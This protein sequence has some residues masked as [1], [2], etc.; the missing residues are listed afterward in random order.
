M[1]KIDA[2]ISD[3]SCTI[4]NDGEGIPIEKN[5]I[6]GVYN[7]TLIFGHLLSGSNYD[8]KQKRFTSGRNGLGAKL[9]N[10]FAKKFTVTGVDETKR[11]Q[12]TQ[13]W[14]NNMRIVSEPKITKSAKKSFTSVSFDIDG[15]L[16]GIETIPSDT[17]SLFARFTLDAAM[18][19][20]LKV[21]LNGVRLPNKLSL[22]L[23]LIDDSP[24][25]CVKF[26]NC[27]SRVW[28]SA[29]QNEKATFEAISFVN[30]SCT[31]NGGRHV[32]AVVEAVCRPIIAKLKGLATLRE[33]KAQLRFL[34]VTRV[35][36]PEYD[37][38]EKNTLESP[39]VKVDPI[40]VAMVNKILKFPTRDGQTIESALKRLRESKEKREISKITS[41]K[42]APPIE[43]YDR[44]NFA[45][46]A[47][48][49]ECVLS[50]CEGLSAKTFAVAGIETGFGGKRGRNYFGIYP[51]KGK[52]LNTR[53]VSTAILSKNVVVM[54]LIKI[55]G[56]DYSNPSNFKNL[57]YGR[58]CTLTDADVDGIHIEC[59]ILNFLHST[60][61]KLLE[62][63]FA[64]GMKTPILKTI[65]A[66]KTRLYFDERSFGKR[67]GC[68]T[69]TS[70]KYFKGLGTTKPE[71]VKHIFGLKI[72][73]FF[74]DDKT[75]KTFEVAFNK[76]DAESR[77]TLLAKYM[78]DLEKDCATLDD[79]TE[80]F[81]PYSISKHLNEQL[82]KF[83]YDDCA[84]TLPSIYDGLKES[85]RKAVYAAKQ[86]NL[87]VDLKV[88]QFGA[89]VA[90]CTNYHHGEVNLFNTIIKMA[91]SFTGS[92][93]VPLFAEEGMFGTRLC[94][95]ED[96]ASPRYIYTKMTKAMI[97]LF[98]DDDIYTS[99]V[100]DGEP[101]EPSYYVPV[102][103]MLL[104][105]GCTGIAS[106]WMCSCPSFSP[107]DVLD[108]ARAAINDRELQPIKPW[109]RGFTGQTIQ[110]ADGKFSTVGTFVR[111][112]SKV[113]VTE[114]P[115]GLWND[116]FKLAC[117]QDE[118]IV[119]V[120]DLSTAKTPSFSLTVAPEFDEV[121]FTKRMTT[122][123]NTNNIVAF[124]DR[125]QI[126]RVSVD[127][128]FK[129]WAKERLRLN[130]IRK[131]S[132]ISKLI[133]K[134][135]RLR[136]KIKFIKLVK[137]RKILLTEKEA[138][139]VKILRENDI[140][141][142]TSHDILLSLPIRTLTDEYQQKLTKELTSCEDT[143]ETMEKLT[144]V[145]IWESDVKK[146]ESILQ[147]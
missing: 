122:L 104:I 111:K 2:T 22:Y 3:T 65:S 28:I 109:F 52:L 27:H 99:K 58:I 88:A 14:T 41:C 77:K 106:G 72:L 108:N 4:I 40:S 8:D 144:A 101:I 143:R 90:E 82:I 1:T 51:L 31:K 73:N 50:V 137:S 53:N 131:R 142:T 102:L 141:K 5:D 55:L 147:L 114:L 87:V 130:E 124:D 80:T 100:D 116:S 57:T 145:D 91:Q 68:T 140:D 89:Y 107:R 129:M 23:N 132:C 117:E 34:I 19:T 126:K 133:E 56:L 97:A 49:S 13:T 35:A 61:P 48:S 7:H 127:N 45:A 29:T 92:N 146:V 9:V 15:A 69:S 79:E 81:I 21:T 110:L 33:V 121:K 85:Q 136:E 123:F 26:D 47:I 135:E 95:G 42:S 32:D 103:P 54:N 18:T 83:F 44:A 63:G 120:K 139:V 105:N 20:G 128:V 59:L 66:G 43:G 70:V 138:D 125:G 6:E 115:V 96:A 71:D 25:L 38:Q 36:N 93:N 39:I 30:G 37:S 75:N 74:V 98:P 64:V 24:P 112:D 76:K 86:K 12:F 119:N 134:M 67:A 113:V 16:F 118:T 94:G 62:S 10:V 60:F 17:K 78:T 46:T 11:L 84:R